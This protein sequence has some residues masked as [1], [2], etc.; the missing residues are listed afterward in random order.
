MLLFDIP[1]GIHRDCQRPFE[2][3]RRAELS[4][5]R[6]LGHCHGQQM[7]QRPSRRINPTSRV[8]R[9]WCDLSAPSAA[10]CGRKGGGS[11]V[12]GCAA[13][14]DLE[15]RPPAASGGTAPS[16]AG[17]GADAGP[18][19]R[20]RLCGALRGR[21]GGGVFGPGAW[22]CALALTGTRSLSRKPVAI[23]DQGS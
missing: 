11:R 14:L 17:A 10:G 7:A 2:M 9:I 12:H 4:Y 21:R 8:S 13:P 22:H 3:L 19:A 16:P 18:V 15:G 1:P 5:T 20:G 6:G 23:R